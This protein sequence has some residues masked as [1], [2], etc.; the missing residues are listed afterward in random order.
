MKSGELTQEDT[1][2][3]MNLSRQAVGRA[4][5][6]ASIDSKLIA[7]FPVVNDL[8]HTDYSILA[9]VM[10]A[11]TDDKK[12]LSSFI[13]KITSKAVNAQ[14]EQS[15]EDVKDEL[16]PCIKTE[17][18]IVEAKQE[19]DKATVIPLAEF[20]SKGMFARKK[21]KGRNFSYEFRRL[22]KDVQAELDAAILAVLSKG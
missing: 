5:K 7:L 19:S 16:I 22:S 6:A 10:K 15:Q 21:V 20:D 18:K 13:K 2:K 8:S 14:P 4:L 17:L 1:A 11:F 3:I 12:A 9:K